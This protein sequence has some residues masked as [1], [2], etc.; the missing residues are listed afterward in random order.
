M[1]EELDSETEL[2]LQMGLPVK[3]G[4]SSYKKNFSVRSS[5]PQELFSE[6]LNGC[7]TL[8]V[9]NKISF[10]ITLLVLYIFGD[11]IVRKQIMAMLS[12]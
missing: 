6:S 11:R 3:F 5:A 12:C 8:T 7:Q 1:E 4:G 9:L 10:T 2:M